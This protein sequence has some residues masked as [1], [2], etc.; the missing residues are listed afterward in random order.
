[1]FFSLWSLY[2]TLKFVTRKVTGRC[3][4]QRICYNNKPGARRTLKI[5]SSLKFSKS[6]VRHIT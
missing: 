3:E 6:G 1:P 5:E 4:M 2:M